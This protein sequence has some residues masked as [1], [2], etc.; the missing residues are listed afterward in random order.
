MPIRERE[1]KLGSVKKEQLPI[2]VQI[3]VMNVLR[4]RAARRE[5]RIH[6]KLATLPRGVS[7]TQIVITTVESATLD[8]G[9]EVYREKTHEVIAPHVAN[10]AT[11]VYVGIG[12]K[13]HFVKALDRRDK[14]YQ[15]ILG[16]IGRMRV[17]IAAGGNKQHY[18]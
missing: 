1:E 11:H 17:P 18:L 13:L 12:G 7:P 5:E 15:P 16:A 9:K 3:A 8:V 4:N 10:G 6:G 14:S 2:E